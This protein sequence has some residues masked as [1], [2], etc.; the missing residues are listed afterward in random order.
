MRREHPTLVEPAD[1]PAAEKVAAAVMDLI[2]FQHLDGE[3]FK[4]G[5]PGKDAP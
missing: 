5:R 3:E 2:G 4:G 1:R